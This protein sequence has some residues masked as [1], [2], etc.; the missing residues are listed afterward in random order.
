MGAGVVALEMAQCFAAFGTEV[1]VLQR[2]RLLSKG[3]DEAAAALK[4]SLEKDGVRFLSGVSVEEVE[5][6]RPGSDE[7]LPL[8]SVSLKCK[9]ESKM[10]K[11]SLECECLLLALGRTANVQ[12]MGLESANVEHHPSQ[13]VLVNDYAQSVSNPNVYAVG[14]CVANVPRLTHSELQCGI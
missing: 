2:S 7:E 11:I 10:S 1:T 8:M 6:L 4:A 5:T 9:E 12:S 13:G 3:D 14:D